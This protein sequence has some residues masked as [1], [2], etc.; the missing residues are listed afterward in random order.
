MN[1][2]TKLLVLALVCCAASVHAQESMYKYPL[3]KPY[4]Y[5]GESKEIMKQEAQGQSVNISSE[6]NTAFQFTVLSRTPEESMKC[7]IDVK[8]AVSFVE[9]PDGME[10]IGQDLANQ[11]FTFSMDNTGGV[12]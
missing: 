3:N 12:S 1:F 11:S 5:V 4:T 6:M 10:T 7:K 2:T 9:T 8:S